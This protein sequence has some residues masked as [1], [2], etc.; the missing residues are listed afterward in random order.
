MFLGLL[1]GVTSAQT[2]TDEM[3]F[4]WDIQPNGSILDGSTDTF[5]GAFT[6][7]AN[8]NPFGG[9]GV[10][11]ANGIITLGPGNVGGINVSRDIMLT[12]QPA[13]IV[14]IDTFENPGGQTLDVNAMN[15]SDMGETAVPQELKSKKGGMQSFVYT[16]QNGRSSVTVVFG[17]KSTKFLPNMTVSGDEL[18]ITFPPF[19]LQGGQKKSIGYFVAQRPTGT[20]SELRDDEKTF[21]KAL[22]QV[23]RKKKFDFLNVAGLGIFSLGNIELIAQGESDFLETRGGDKVFG[24]L[25]TNEFVLETALGKRTLPVD[26]IVNIIGNDG[27]TFQVVSTDGSALTGKLQPNMIQ[28]DLTDGGSGTIALDEVA[29]I[30]PK[31]TKKLDSKKKEQWFQFD[32]PL[33]VFKNEDRIAGEL[34]S[35][36]ISVHTSIGKLE[37][38]LDTMR[39]IELNRREGAVNA[40]AFVTKDG[41]KFS[42]VF[43]DQMEVKVWGEKLIKISPSSLKT[44]F[45]TA[46]KTDS[47]D[48]D[49]ENNRALLRLSDSE[50][51]FARI[52]SAEKPLEFQ[53]AFG[54]RTIDPQQISSL[55]NVPGLAGEMKILL[56]DGSNLTGKLTAD[57]ILFEVLDR[58]IELLPSMVRKYSNPQA[59][60]PESLRKKYIDLIAQLG[61]PKFAE[62]QAAFER[63]EKDAEKIKGLLESQLAESKNTETQARILKLL[64]RQ[65]EGKKGTEEKKEAENQAPFG[66]QQE[67]I[68][69]QIQKVANENPFK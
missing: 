34:E 10:Q 30:V 38:P 60:P 61:S 1:T 67:K 64:G 20:G 32:K 48:M 8:S 63:L 14:I 16:Q 29:R 24:N 47:L 56:W 19:K 51:L 15:Y 27:R 36:S 39:S 59:I 7:Y 2:V 3:G 18:T 55:E 43:Y 54:T 42:G 13:G 44:I 31:R 49:V 21:A 52:K 66:L 37:L 45:L 65:D 57:H 23:A 68:I 41:Q 17:D 40:A 69:E 33:F 12:T 5:D 62:R 50:F 46:E 58:D 6:L 53:T 22:G 9:G 26:T 11:Q 25:A 28:F 4:L 35:R